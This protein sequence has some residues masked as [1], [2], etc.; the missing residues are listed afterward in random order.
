MICPASTISWT[1]EWSRVSSLQGSVAQPVAAGISHV[2]EQQV[3]YLF[4]NHRQGRR[5]RSCRVPVVLEHFRGDLGDHVGVDI[6]GKAGGPRWHCGDRRGDIVPALVRGLDLQQR[7]QGGAA[8]GFQGFADPV[9]GQ[10][11]LALDLGDGGQLAH[12][13]LVCEGAN[14]LHGFDREL[15]GHFPG[16]VPAHSVGHRINDVMRQDAVLVLAA[17]PSN[18]GHSGGGQV[19]RHGCRFIIH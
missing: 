19:E 5:A 14:F 13:G 11:D 12:R 18:V 17:A 16:L 8:A 15:A 1:A 2:D 6:H 3:G 4:G 9:I 10:L 7:A